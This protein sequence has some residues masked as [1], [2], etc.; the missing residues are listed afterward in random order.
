M[1]IAKSPAKAKK[2]LQKIYA[3]TSGPKN[4]KEYIDEIE[5]ITS[6]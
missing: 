1:K 4:K 3:D 6:D 5:L 2:E